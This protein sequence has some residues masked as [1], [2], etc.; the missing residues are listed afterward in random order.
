R[1]QLR[2]ADTA[3]AAK[4]YPKA[5]EL[6]QTVLD[7]DAENERAA[8]LLESAEEGLQRERDARD[9]VQDRFRNRSVAGAETGADA[10]PE[11]AAEPAEVALSSLRVE[12]FSEVSEGLLSV[13]HGGDQLLNEKFAF[14][15]KGS[16]VFSRDRKTSGRMTAESAVAAG[17]SRLRVYVYSNGQTRSA[18]LDGTLSAG[19]SH[20]L[21]IRVDADGAVSA[22]FE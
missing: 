1:E 17:A 4:D 14:V 20:V 19:G 16:G 7:F 5:I 3:L 22:S 18:E 21:D 9:R 10:P 6:A 15:E 13:F 8:A 12:F 11:R 2:Q